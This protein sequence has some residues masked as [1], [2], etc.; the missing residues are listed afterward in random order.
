MKFRLIYIFILFLS[1]KLCVHNIEAQ[2]IVN[3]TGKDSLTCYNHSDGNLDLSVNGGI[4]PYNFLWEDGSTLN[5]RNNLQKGI[6]YCT[7]SDNSIPKL[8]KVDSFR[9][10]APNDPIWYINP[11]FKKWD[12][13]TGWLTLLADSVK[14]ITFPIQSYSGSQNGQITWNPYFYTIKFPFTIESIFRDKP[15]NYNGLGDALVRD[16]R[17]CVFFEYLPMDTIFAKYVSVGFSVYPFQN[18]TLIH[19]GES[20]RLGV[21]LNSVNYT[22]SIAINWYE[23]NQLIHCSYCKSIRINPK[24]DTKYRVEV[25]TKA[26][27]CIQ[28]HDFLVNVIKDSIIN[29]ENKAYIPNIFSPD[30]NGYNDYFIPK[31]NETLSKIKKMIV[32]NRWGGILFEKSDFYPTSEID[33]WDGRVNDK[34]LDEGVYLYYIEAEF[35]DKTIEKYKGDVYLQH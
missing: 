23:N 35:K 27:G 25:S 4:K 12:C 18:D 32:F 17:G 1:L 7:V 3:H 28:S 2:L 11:S 6:Y 24:T 14:N 13:K 20:I 9:I 19:E 34:L 30:F 26:V 16:S 21:L 31:F 22:D 29:P 10:I 33:G 5:T 15:Y 8:I